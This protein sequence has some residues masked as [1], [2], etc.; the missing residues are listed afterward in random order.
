MIQ[1]FL[2]IGIVAI[3]VSGMFLGVWTSGQQQRS[4]YHSETKEHRAFRLKVG[5]FSGLIG[6]VS[7]GL[8]GLLFYI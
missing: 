7:L 1:L 5:I 2:I 4:N 8:A 3:V 6:L